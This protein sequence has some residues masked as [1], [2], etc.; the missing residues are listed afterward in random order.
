[1]FETVSGLGASDGQPGAR[2]D[3]RRVLSATLLFCAV[4]I[5]L[6]TGMSA[7]RVYALDH[8]DEK[9]GDRADNFVFI[10]QMYGVF[11]SAVFAPLFAAVA[12][13]F[14]KRHDGLWKWLPLGALLS[15]LAASA[16]AFSR[17]FF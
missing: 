9:W 14:V 10:V 16:A 1:M 8:W 15:G 5:G 11:V 7:F 13:F 3:F 17:V 4:V 12:W 2:P 6:A